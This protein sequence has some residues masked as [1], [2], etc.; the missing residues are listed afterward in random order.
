MANNPKYEIAGRIAN[1]KFFS[2]TLMPVCRNLWAKSN[3][4]SDK[5]ISQFFKKAY[6]ELGPMK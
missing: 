6:N 1:V 2:I 3:P 5:R 4:E